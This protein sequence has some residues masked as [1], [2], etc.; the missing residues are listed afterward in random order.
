MSS[1]RTCV[2]GS[3]DI[4]AHLVAEVLPEVPIRQWE[5]VV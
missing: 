2:A 3:S 5:Y 4:A 1:M